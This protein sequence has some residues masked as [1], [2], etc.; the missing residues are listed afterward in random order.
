MNEKGNGK[1]T[2]GTAF[3][4]INSGLLGIVIFFLTAFFNRFER[5]EH[6]QNEILQNQKVLQN[7]VI[8]IDKKYEQFDDSIKELNN[9]LDEVIQ[10]K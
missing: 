4:F 7:E 5:I 9:K 1:I 2:W 3:K 6:V 10:N 8:H